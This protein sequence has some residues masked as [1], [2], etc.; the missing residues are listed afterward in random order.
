MT[1]TDRPTS[2][3]A[4][5]V[6]VRGAATRGRE[7]LLTHLTHGPKTGQ[8]SSWPAVGTSPGTLAVRGGPGQTTCC[9]SAQL[10]SDSLMPA[11]RP[12]RGTAA[13]ARD[14]CTS[15]R[16]PQ[17][18]KGPA[19]STYEWRP[20]TPPSTWADV[21]LF[22]NFSSPEYIMALRGKDTCHLPARARRQSSGTR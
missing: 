1:D 7:L 4:L 18:D 22:S 5:L 14:G 15:T 13:E 20:C 9:G 16:P 8:N 11:A 12:A 6:P 17:G 3:E 10:H 21:V 19:Q 2:E